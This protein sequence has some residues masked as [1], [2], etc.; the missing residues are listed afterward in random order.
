MHAGR[1]WRQTCWLAATLLVVGAWVLL[2]SACTA[3]VMA[4]QGGITSDDVSDVAEKMYCPVCENIPLDDCGT[5]AC[6]DW[7]QEIRRQ[8]GQGMTEDEIIDGFVARY[9]EQVVGIPRDATLRSISLVT[10][11]LLAAI[12]AAV[13]IGLM[14]RW[15]R[16]AQAQPSAAAPVTSAPPADTDSAYRQQL[17]RD[18]SL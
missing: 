11:W 9:G 7:K 2:L 10:P 1:S 16:T 17:E 14:R 5:D 8:L 6:M 18:L 3:T 4:Q 12:V 13:G 15:R